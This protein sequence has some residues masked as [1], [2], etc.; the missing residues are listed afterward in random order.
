[1]RGQLKTRAENIGD[2]KTPCPAGEA[3]G[4]A[5]GKEA[6]RMRKW[7]ISVAALAAL[8]GAVTAVLRRSR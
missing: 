8:A 7:I 5:D 6:N 1:M 2:E 4:G 3:A